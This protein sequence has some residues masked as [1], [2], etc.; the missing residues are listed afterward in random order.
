M[1]KIKE[2]NILF[3]CI[4][5]NILYKY[6]GHYLNI[7]QRLLLIPLYPVSPSFLTGKS[8]ILSCVHSYSE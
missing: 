8:L 2:N 5:Y 6:L 7:W 1:S 4:D 3:I